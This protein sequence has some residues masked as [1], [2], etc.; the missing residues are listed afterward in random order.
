MKN[1]IPLASEPV[2]VPSPSLQ[3]A[4]LLPAC[5]CRF[6][7]MGL[8]NLIHTPFTSLRLIRKY[9]YVTFRPQAALKPRGLG[10]FWAQILYDCVAI[11]FLLHGHSKPLVVATM[12]PT[13]LQCWS[14]F[15]GLIFLNTREALPCWSCF[16]YC[17]QCMNIRVL[18]VR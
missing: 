11:L 14:L 12:S 1:M 3:V 9:N 4:T 15:A 17:Y 7:W 2:I 10:A 18:Y 16:L 6:W 5:A 8:K 13:L